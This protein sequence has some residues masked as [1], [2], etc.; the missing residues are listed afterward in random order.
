MQRMAPMSFS[1]VIPVYRNEEFLEQLVKNLEATALQL[2]GA[3]EVVFVVDGS[4]D[5]S[6]AR[7]Q[8]LLPR[9]RF[10][11]KLL[12]LSRNYGSFS[13]IAAGLQA[14][15]GAYLC[16]IAADLQEPPQ[17]PLQFF[18]ELLKGD[19]DMVLGQREGRADPWLS[20]TYSKVFWSFYC[21]FIQQRM[22]AGGIDVFA[23][24]A[25]VRDV[26]IAMPEANTSLV[27][28]LVWL[29]FRQRLVPY[30]RLPRTSGKSAW[31]FRRKIRYLKDS[32]F[33]FSD[34][35]I[36]ALGFIGALG[37]L[38]SAVMG[39][40]ILLAKG[41][42]LIEVPGYTATIATILFF[43]GLNSLGISMIGEYLWRTFENSKQRPRYVVMFEQA[44]PSTPATT[45]PMKDS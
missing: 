8:E 11:S 31:N 42:G 44:F 45:D 21:R 20:R 13:A 29:G 27:G 19:C 38:A 14:A 24:T 26:L 1:I 40:I 23:C 4:P 10:T 37:L 39:I 41:F 43:G 30:Q 6:H 9:A 17:L 18:N 2:P 36:R 28:L 25:K 12:L 34:L 22:P 3:L 16:V 15:S 35:P 32:V 7:L 5:R 33:A